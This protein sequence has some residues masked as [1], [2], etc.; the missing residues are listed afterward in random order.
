MTAYGSESIG[1]VYSTRC[2]SLLNRHALICLSWLL[3]TKCMMF[4]FSLSLPFC[5][6]YFS[7]KQN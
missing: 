3:C 4:H 1:L 2:H 7:L 6:C 5:N